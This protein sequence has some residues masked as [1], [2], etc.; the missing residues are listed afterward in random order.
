MLISL[1]DNFKE[2]GNQMK[3]LALILTGLIAVT[4]SFAAANDKL[5]TSAFLKIFNELHQ[6]PLATQSP[7]KRA[8]VQTL[9]IEQKLDH[10]DE[11]ET[12]TWKMVGKR[13]NTGCH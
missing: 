3:K 12:R 7:V 13:R 5:E 8:N 4:A 1:H 10:F 11:N 2:H 6:D 9:W